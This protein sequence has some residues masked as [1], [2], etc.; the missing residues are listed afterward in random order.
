M[1]TIKISELAS[2]NIALTDFFAKA[3]ANGVASKNTVQEL[4]NLLKTVDDT[5]FKGSIAI[6][7]VPSENGWYFASESGT[8]TNCGGLVIDTTDNIAIIIVSGTFDTFNK[9]DIPVN[10]TIDATPTDGSLNAVESNGVFDYVKNENLPNTQDVY[11]VQSLKWQNNGFI[12]SGGGF[13]ANLAYRSTDFIPCVGN[14]VLYTNVKTDSAFISFYTGV[15]GSE[16]F[17]S[18]VIKNN[19]YTEEI[20]IPSTAT[21]VRLPTDI[22]EQPFPFVLGDVTIPTLDFKIE[23]NLSLIRGSMYQLNIFLINGSYFD[24]N[25][26]LQ[27][28]ISFEYAEINISNYVNKDIFINTY[29]KS[30]AYCHFKD[31]DGNIVSSFQADTVISGGVVINVPNNSVTLC[32]SNDKTNISNPFT[33]VNVS[34]KLSEIEDEH[35][36]YEQKLYWRADFYYD[37]VGNIIEF[38]G[39]EVTELNVADNQGN[40]IILSA[41]STSSTHCGWKDEDDVLILSFNIQGVETIEVPSNAVTLFLSNYANRPYTPSL[42][43]AI[44]YGIERTNRILPYDV[45]DDKKGSV[46]KVQLDNKIADT[47]LPSWIGKSELLTTDLV[48]SINN[49]GQSYLFDNSGTLE[50]RIVKDAETIVGL[51]LTTKVSNTITPTSISMVHFGDSIT[52]GAGTVS[53]NHYVDQLKD[54]LE[55][56]GHT[57][58]LQTNLGISGYTA[59]KIYENYK[60]TTAVAHDIA[61]LMVGINDSHR[62]L[63]DDNSNWKQTGLDTIGFRKWYRFY[64]SKAVET[65]KNYSNYS[66]LFL[67]VPYRSVIQDNGGGSYSPSESYYF[68]NPLMEIIFQEVINFSENNDDIYLCRADYYVPLNLTNMPDRLH[69]STIGA[70]LL[71]EGIRNEITFRI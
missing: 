26:D 51:N 17:L 46:L 29:A 30:S 71:A 36:I 5:A 2:S 49:Q 65:I 56:D 57:I 22:N 42:K 3:D 7:D 58:S 37:S 19:L 35:L 48:P 50:L 18:G 27:V 60:D 52:E 62:W 64:L 16:V 14:G 43:F 61:T 63:L 70:E 59:Q 24:I 39:Y 13:V 23:D 28:S 6:A 4:S 10:I 32:L 33:K 69:P 34:D 25:G 45:I 31:I 47:G 1:S 54:K 21:F 38:D 66:K 9:I 12:D 55:V 41:D 44:D 40:N 11:E 68:S 15:E 8:Y 53:G 67:I 20:S